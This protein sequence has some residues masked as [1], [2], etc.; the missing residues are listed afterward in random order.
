V[1][2]VLCAEIRFY[3]H[4]I[5]DQAEASQKAGTIRQL[6][7]LEVLPAKDWFGVAC[8]ATGFDPLPILKKML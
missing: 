4:R 6:P 7:I 2:G 8:L 5:V 3:F 1:R